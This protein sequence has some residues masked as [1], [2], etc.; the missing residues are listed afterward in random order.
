MSKLEEIKISVTISELKSFI[1][2][3]K[4]LNKISETHKLKFADNAI[5]FYTVK[6]EDNR[7]FDVFKSFMFK[8]DRLFSDMNEDLN[9]SIIFD[10]S[11]K[12]L[13]KFDFLTSGEEDI[14]MFFNYEKSTGIVN[15]LRLCNSTLEL[16]TVTGDSNIIIDL[17]IDKIKENMN[18]D[19][20][21]GRFSMTTEQLT[22]IT[23]LSALNKTNDL[24]SIEID[25]YNVKFLENGWSL[26]IGTSTIQTGE[27][28]FRK[29]YLKYIKPNDDKLDFYLYDTFILINE[30][31]SHLMMNLDLI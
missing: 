17:T 23:K 20:A 12:M 16:T 9:L 27:Y 6:G 29:E 24:L 13:T 4:E 30:F 28:N 26:N 22:K 25:N 7:R 15:S 18:P 5:L 14:D 2:M 1:G 10:D 31:K 8:R 21:N 11:K 19:K 3:L